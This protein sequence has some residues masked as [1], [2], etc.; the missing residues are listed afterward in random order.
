MQ[1]CILDEESQNL[2]HSQSMIS[3]FR[4][5]KEF[6]WKKTISFFITP[7]VKAKQKVANL[8]SCLRQCV[9]KLYWSEIHSSI[10]KIFEIE[11][12]ETDYIL[13]LSNIP[14]SV[15]NIKYLLRRLLAAAK[16]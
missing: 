16:K 14:D 1:I 2:W 3:L 5:L 4:A 15:N 10:E 8:G 11:I 9:L 13:Y 7:K 12:G 6:C